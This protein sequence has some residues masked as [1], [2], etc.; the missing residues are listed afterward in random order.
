MLILTR[1]VGQ[2]IFIG[3]DIVVKILEP[4]NYYDKS[5]RIGIQ[6]PKDV[7]IL[8]EEVPKLDA[9]EIERK[10]RFNR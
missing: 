5:I 7:S 10:K 2:A 8:R 9:K 6:A 4:Q 1:R 3:D